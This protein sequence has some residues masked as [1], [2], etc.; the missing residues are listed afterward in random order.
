VAAR[1][2][3]ISEHDCRIRDDPAAA[4]TPFDANADF[5]VVDLDGSHLRQSDALS[6]ADPRQGSCKPGR[7]VGG[8]EGREAPIVHDDRP[9]CSGALA[10]IDDEAL[11]ALPAH[12]GQPPAVASPFDELELQQTANMCWLER[13]GAAEADFAKRRFFVRAERCEHAPHEALPLLTSSLGIAARVRQGLLLLRSFDPLRL[14]L[15]GGSLGKQGVS[16]RLQGHGSSHSPDECG[17]CPLVACL[18]RGPL[19]VFHGARLLQS[20]SF[21]VARG[22]DVALAL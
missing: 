14:S 7:Q 20:N 21:N 11:V 19:V 8:R 5:I 4:A 12:D 13:I 22:Q 1:A 3:A 6:F 15:D 17:Q 18:S 2:R 16:I 9:S 10:H